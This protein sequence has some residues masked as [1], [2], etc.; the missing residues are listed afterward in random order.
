MVCVCYSS[1]TATTS[2][3]TNTRTINACSINSKVKARMPIVPIKVNSQTGCKVVYTLLDTGSDESIISNE[4][5]KD[6]TL[7][8]SACH[9]VFWSL[10][11]I[12]N[13]Y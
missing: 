5:F 10:L 1:E 8:G 11:I 6:L 4:L 13:H 12:E 9:N 7:S 2:T 3:A